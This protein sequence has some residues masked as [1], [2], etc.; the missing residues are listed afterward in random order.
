MWVAKKGPRVRTPQRPMST[1]GTPASSSMANPRGR[2]IH[3]GMRSVRAKAAPIEM[4]RAMITAMADVWNVPTMS[5]H[6]P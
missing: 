2:E 5:G 6:S 4:G 1:L 3:S